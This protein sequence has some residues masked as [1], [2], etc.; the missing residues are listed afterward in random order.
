MCAVHIGCLNTVRKIVFV[1]TQYVQYKSEFCVF[2]D[3]ERGLNQMLKFPFLNILYK[4]QK[5]EINQLNPLSFKEGL[6]SSTKRSKYFVLL[7]KTILSTSC[8]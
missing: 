1:C 4:L 5:P 2:E 8:L 6:A 3:D 7:S